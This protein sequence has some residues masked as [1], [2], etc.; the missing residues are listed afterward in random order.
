LRRKHNTF[1]DLPI[2]KKKQLFCGIVALYLPSGQLAG[3]VHYLTTCEEIY[4]IAILP[5]LHRPG[6]LGTDNPIHRH[7][8]ATP[9]DCF[10]SR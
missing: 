8:L 10:W 6:I 2:A 3:N 4:D 9:T 7:A 5:N 1:G